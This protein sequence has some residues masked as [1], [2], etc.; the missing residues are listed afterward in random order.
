MSIREEV[1]SFANADDTYAVVF[2]GNGATGAIN[3]RLH[4]SGVNHRQ[5]VVVLLGPYEHH[6]TILPTITTSVEVAHIQLSE[7][8]SVDLKHLESV[9]KD[10]EQRGKQ[11]VGMFF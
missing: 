4:I 2:V 3:R 9:L 11:P 6:A 8:G 5:D 10:C 7:N 1:R